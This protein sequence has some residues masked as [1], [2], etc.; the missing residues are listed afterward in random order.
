VNWRGKAAAGVAA[1]ALLVAGCAAAA[2]LSALQPGPVPS[3]GSAALPPS[4]AGEYRTPKIQLGIDVDA[5]TYPGE[6]MA[7]AARAVIKY[8]RSLHANAI[9]FTFPF[10]MNGPHAATVS[11]RSSTPTPHMIET[12]ARIAEAHGLYVAFR[13]LLDETSIDHEFRGNLRLSHPAE[14]FTSYRRFLLPYAKVAQRVKAQEFVVGTELSTLYKSPRWYPLDAAIRRVYD[15]SLAFDSNWYGVSSLQGAGGKGL[16]EGV[17]AYPTIPTQIAEGWRLYD[18]RLPRGTVEMEVGIAAVR[19][20]NAAP[21]KHSWPGKP[22]DG[23]V[24]AQWFSA[25]C[26][27]AARA[28]LGGIYFWSVGLGPT[29]PG[30]TPANSLNWGGGS[31][32]SK[33]ISACFKSL[34]REAGR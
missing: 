21:Y 7:T 4:V 8:V 25:A 30:P 19:G 32:G 9:S 16:V 11:I 15:G 31:P 23:K 20:A 2:H 34:S 33:A 17:D 29:F 14:W 6:D 10:F 27:A 18:R 5:Y 22:I 3:S 24:Q 28:H 26:H 12:F 13:P 1:G